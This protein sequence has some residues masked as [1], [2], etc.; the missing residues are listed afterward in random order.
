[1]KFLA[2]RSR[3]TAVV[4]GAAM[5]TL[6]AGG[7]AFASGLVT[8][9]DIKNKT[10]EAVDMATGSVNS[11]VIADNSVRSKDIKDGSVRAKDLRPS[12]VNQLNRTRQVTTLSHGRFHHTNSSVTMTPDGVQYGPYADGGAAGGSV[13]FTGLNGMKLS[14]VKNLVYYMRY[15]ASNDTGGVGVPYLRIFLNSDNDDAIFSPNTQS[16]NPDIAQG[17]F[18]E[19]VATS[20]SWRY[21]DDGGNG[22]DEPFS[23]LVA[24]HGNDTVSGIYLSSGFTAG[25][26]LS[27]LLRWMQINGVTYNF[28]S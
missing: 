25:Q 5:L 12:V 22:P 16:P 1:V 14:D 4:A 3:T 9:Q 19:W 28:G 8:S 11:R 20:G 7:G 18:H 17:P 6:A 24:D 2:I 10:I 26:N 21:D 15:T 23:Q 27:S 13:E